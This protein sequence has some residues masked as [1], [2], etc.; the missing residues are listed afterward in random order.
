MFVTPQTGVAANPTSGNSSNASRY[1]NTSVPA[2]FDVAN[3]FLSVNDERDA[4]GVDARYLVGSG[5]LGS[6]R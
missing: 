3:N 5:L 1:V 2:T 6:C 4:D